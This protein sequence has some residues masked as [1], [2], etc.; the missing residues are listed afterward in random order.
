[1]RRWLVLLA[2]ALGSG[3]GA[4]VL[5]LDL[6]A[7]ASAA[8]RPGKV[9]RVERA[10]QAFAGVPRFCAVHPGDLFGHCTGPKGPEVGDRLTAIDNARVLGLLR[11][12]RVAPYPDGCQQTYQWMIEVAVD[13]GD[14]SSSRGVVLGLS[15]VAVDSRQSRLINVDK[16]PTGH[17][18]GIDTIYAID[19]NA[20]GQPELSFVQFTC[21]DTGAPSLAATS[22]CHEVWATQPGRNLPERLRHDRF[23]VCY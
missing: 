9:V 5:S 10:P 3:A 15:D 6:V 19:N 22:H 18:W 1:M 17:P 20:D 13:S 21:D 11:V 7:S 16:S 14:I 23:K 4:F 2:I 8:P 12:T